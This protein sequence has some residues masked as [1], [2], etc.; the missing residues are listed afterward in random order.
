MATTD[1]LYDPYVGVL[2]GY[3]EDDFL[4]CQRAASSRRHR[5]GAICSRQPDEKGGWVGLY[6]L[7]LDA[8]RYAGKSQGFTAANLPRTATPPHAEQLR[9]ETLLRSATRQ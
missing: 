7:E 2:D 9:V 4:V 3:R 8:G 1:F 5:V 6:A